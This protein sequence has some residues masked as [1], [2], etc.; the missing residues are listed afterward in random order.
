MASAFI[1]LIASAI[2]AI[3]FLVMRNPMR[4]TMLS[5]ILKAIIKEWF[6]TVF[7]AIRCA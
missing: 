6:S 1:L 4:L 3:D 2:A 5:P 7:T